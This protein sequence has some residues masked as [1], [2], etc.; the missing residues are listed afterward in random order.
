MSTTQP[1]EREEESAPPQAQRPTESNIQNE[2]P[3][4]Q[5]HGLQA[6]EPKT[7]VTLPEH[8][9]N[10]IISNLSKIDRVCLSLVK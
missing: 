5:E 2:L 1:N 6:E 9:H 8:I 10:K 4:F 7:F 3:I